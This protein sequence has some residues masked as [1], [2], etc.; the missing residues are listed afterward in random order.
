MEDLF[1]D[2]PV[3]PITKMQKFSLKTTVLLAEQM[4]ERINFL[5]D[6]N[7]I[8]RDIKPDNFVVKGD[9]VYMIDFGEL[10][11]YSYLSYFRSVERLIAWGDSVPLRGCS[12]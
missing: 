9:T 4:L 6:K 2:L 3:N 12:L 5:H 7:Y 11:S 8:H 1:N 10:L